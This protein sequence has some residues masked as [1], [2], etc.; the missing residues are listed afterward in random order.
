MVFAIAFIALFTVGCASDAQYTALKNRYEYESS[1][2]DQMVQDLQRRNE[3]LERQLSAYAREASAFDA[4]ADFLKAQRDAAIAQMQELELEFADLF[5]AKDGFLKGVATRNENNGWDFDSEMLFS[6]GKATLSSEGKRILADV[7]SRV[8]G[9]AINLIIVGHT[10][11]QPIR[12]SLAQNPTGMNLQLGA[13]R[14]IAVAEAFNK[15]GVHETRMQVISK[16]MAEPKA[17]NTSKASMKLNRRVEIYFVKGTSS[18][19]HTPN[20]GD[21]IDA[22]PQK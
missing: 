11:N 13:R 18:A 12:R 3:D 10:D 9:E 8:K 4:Q 6:P 20:K 2:H 7:A 21:A 22:T 19:M 15:S 17:E 5:N 16:G 1:L 14:A